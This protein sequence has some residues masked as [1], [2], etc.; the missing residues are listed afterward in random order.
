MYTKYDLIFVAIMSGFWGIILGL[1]IMAVCS[2]DDYEIGY[3][4]GKE[5]GRE[6]EKERIRSETKKQF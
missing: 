3:E 1:L 2:K 5:E 4:K 6:E